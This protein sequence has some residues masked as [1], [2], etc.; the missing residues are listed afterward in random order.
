LWGKLTQSEE[1]E[2][3]GGDGWKTSWGEERGEEETGGILRGEIGLDSGSYSL[4]GETGIK[5]GSGQE[6]VFMLGLGKVDSL[7]WVVVVGLTLHPKREDDG[8]PPPPP[9]PILLHL[10]YLSTSHIPTPVSP[11][12]GRRRRD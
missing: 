10:Q 11:P 6:T 1:R 4:G 8:H 5:K 3:V 12:T 2:V 9:A 7:S